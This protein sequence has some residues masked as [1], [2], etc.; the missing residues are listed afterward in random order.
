MARMFR[1][2]LKKVCWILIFLSS[3]AFAQSDIQSVHIEPLTKGV[4]ASFVELDGTSW[5]TVSSV[6]LRGR[7]EV[8]MVNRS[9]HATIYL[10]GVSINTVSVYPL[11]PRQ[12]IKLKISSDLPL[13]ASSNTATSFSTIEI[14]LEYLLRYSFCFPFQRLPMII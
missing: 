6:E 13:Y 11:Y 10:S 9:T 12:W 3:T 7:K 2:A 5:V 8:L 14:K 1:L 4:S